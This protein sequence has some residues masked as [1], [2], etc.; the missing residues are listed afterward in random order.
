MSRKQLEDFIRFAEANSLMN[1]PFTEVWEMYNDPNRLPN[2]PKEVV[3][4]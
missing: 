1:M 4:C 2:P 3:I